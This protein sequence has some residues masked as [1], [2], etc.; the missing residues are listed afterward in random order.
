[1]D[2]EGEN[3]VGQHRDFEAGGGSGPESSPPADEPPAASTFDLPSI[4]A[5]LDDPTPATRREAVA[6]IRD[7]IDHEER[8]ERCLP[9]V[10]KLRTLLEVSTTEIDFHDE[11]AYCLA[12]LAAESPTDVAPSTDAIAGFVDEHASHAAT[13]DLVRCLAAVATDRPVAVSDHLEALAIGLDHESSA[14]RADAA[15]ALTRVVRGA[16]DD[17]AGAELNSDDFDASLLWGRLLELLEDERA[18]V[19]ENACRALGSMAELD[20]PVETELDAA[21]D[22]LASL[23]GE[24]SVP[25]VRERAEWALERLSEE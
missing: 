21:R 22:R 18:S 23:A 6:R 3:A 8:P 24:D 10:P 25:A 4:L 12:E 1:M 2:G 5:R 14:A 17:A 19:R 7:A 11:V 13:P 9:A 20:G 16:T 15:A